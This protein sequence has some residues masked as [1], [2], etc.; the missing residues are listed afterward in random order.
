MSDETLRLVVRE[1]VPAAMRL[2]DAAGWNQTERDWEVFLELQ[3]DG[4][5]GIFS[6]GQLAATSA[7]YC[8]GRELAWIGMVLTAPEARRRGYAR[9]LMQ[10]CLEE[11][12]RRGVSCVKLDAT[13]MGRSLY[14]ALGF[15]DEQPV[16]RWEG[17][18]QPAT[19]REASAFAYDP[20]LDRAA[21]GAC[22]S[23]LLH[24]LARFEAAAK[25]GVGY[26]MGRP[27][28]KAAYLGPCVSRSPAGARELLEWYLARHAGERVFWDLLPRNQSAL[29]LARAFGFTPVR[30]LT[31][32]VLG[33]GHARGPERDDSLVYALAGFEYG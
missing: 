10:H 9:R 30:Q 21:F 5:W 12:E 22:R 11:L 24:A 7:F 8:Y 2:K 33:G 29:A 19:A 1:D 20:A 17:V 18:A 26:V 3:P 13:D 16:A 15:E 25:P 31:R 27:G 28:T 14:R 32:M 6:S 23:R 4:C